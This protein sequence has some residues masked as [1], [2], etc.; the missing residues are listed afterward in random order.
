M[1]DF[2]CSA[3]TTNLSCGKGGFGVV[4]GQGADV[5]LFGRAAGNKPN[6]SGVAKKSVGGS[7]APDTEFGN[8]VGGDEELFFFESGG[9]GKEGG[10]VSVVAD[11]EKDEVEAG[12]IAE[13]GA[14]LFF[15]SAG[16]DFGGGDFAMNAFDM[17]AGTMKGFVD[18]A[19]VTVFVVGGDPPFV[20]EVEAGGGPGPF[21]LGEA[22]IEGFGGGASGE[23]DV[24]GAAG[25]EGGAAEGFPG[26]DH[27]VE[28]RGRFRKLVQNHKKRVP[29][30]MIKAM[31]NSEVEAGS[32]RGMG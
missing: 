23:R 5:G 31:G 29:K 17:D 13:V 21:E 15:V 16:T 10:G 11:A 24:E 22:L 4:L 19:V 6:S 9:F 2:D 30:F 3:V 25:L 32:F 14:D 28:P 27:G 18:H 8:E 20:S 26:C 1:V 7:Y 12:G